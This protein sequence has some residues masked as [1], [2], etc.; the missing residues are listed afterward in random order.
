MEEW[1]GATVNSGP[2][3]GGS[4][5]GIETTAGLHADGPIMPRC[6]FRGLAFCELD[7]LCIACVPIPQSSGSGWVHFS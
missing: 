5:G 2:A 6:N 3:A 7:S 4:R 1:G